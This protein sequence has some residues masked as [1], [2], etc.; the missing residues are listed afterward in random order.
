M[1]TAM[2]QNFPGESGV[3]KVVTIGKDGEPAPY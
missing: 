1:V 2:F 3:T